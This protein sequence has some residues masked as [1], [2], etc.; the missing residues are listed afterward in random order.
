[1]LK[2]QKGTMRM[3]VHMGKRWND[4]FLMLLYSLN[5]PC[6]PEIQ[7]LKAYF[8]V[9]AAGTWWSSGGQLISGVTGFAWLHPLHNVVL[10]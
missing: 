3:A 4:P 1:M 10:L 6:D 7:G 5:C 9:D 2:C 8:L